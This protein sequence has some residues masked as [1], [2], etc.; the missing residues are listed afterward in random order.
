[1][2]W[3][4]RFNRVD[5]PSAVVSIIAL[6]YMKHDLSSAAAADATLLPEGMAINTTLD[7]MLDPNAPMLDMQPLT[8]WLRAA[9]VLMLWARIPRLLFLSQRRWPLVLML[10]KMS[11]RMWGSISLLEVCY[12]SCCSAEAAVR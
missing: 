1:L 8:R 4:D 9:A 11:T 5:L 10:F 2:Y 7:A 3:S 6:I 12:C